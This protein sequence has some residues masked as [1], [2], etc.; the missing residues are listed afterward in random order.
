[1]HKF[2]DA[3][4]IWDVIRRRV[5]HKRNY[6]VA[7]DGPDCSGKSTL[8]KS[9]VA[10][11]LADGFTATAVHLD[12]TFVREVTR[13]R[14]NPDAVS[15]FLMEFFSYEDL[16]KSLRSFGG[17]VFLDGMFLLRPSLLNLYDM[18][19]R[20][21][22]DEQAVFERAMLRDLAEFATWGDCALHY[23][24][25]AL[26]AQRLYRWFCQPNVVADLT[27]YLGD[28]AVAPK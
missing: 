24:S 17:L 2:A 6:V 14:R 7:I 10:K 5:M 26:A 4:E 1:L 9:L 21:E 15:E 20:L 25:Q 8:A 12:E 18:T 16:P 13:P 23:V 3:S 28:N 19:I 27:I 22:L 11:A